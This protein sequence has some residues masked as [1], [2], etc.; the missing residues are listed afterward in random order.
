MELCAERTRLEST[1][2]RHVGAQRPGTHGFQQLARAQQ[3]KTGN[4]QISQPRKRR[5]W[6]ISGRNL[7]E[8]Q[9]GQIPLG[10]VRRA[11]GRNSRENPRSLAAVDA[12]HGR[13]NERILRGRP[14]RECEAAHSTEPERSRE[15]DAH[16]PGHAITSRSH[17]V[18]HSMAYG[19]RM[20]KILRKNFGGSRYGF[21]V[22]RT[23]RPNGNPLIAGLRVR[24]RSW[25]TWYR[26]DVR[27]CGGWALAVRT[28]R[29]RRPNAHRRR[30]SPRT[31]FVL[32]E[33]RRSGRG[34]MRH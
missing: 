26:P 14:L 6:L 19:W 34:L 12:T 7:R 3:P 30:A 29:R 1:Q 8:L 25:R 18:T 22:V 15:S 10:N 28:W 2:L 23:R 13:R 17:A 31:D 5:V 21:A 11:G 33:L 24:P 9:H 27:R 4:E 32:A 16:A 20:R